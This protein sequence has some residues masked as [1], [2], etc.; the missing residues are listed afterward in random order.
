M[1][2][3]F[4]VAQVIQEFKTGEAEQFPYLVWQVSEA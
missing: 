3:T 4:L 2:Q 1:E